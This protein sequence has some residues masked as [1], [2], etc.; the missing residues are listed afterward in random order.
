M[1]FHSFDELAQSRKEWYDVSA[2][3]GFL[4]GIEL[5]LTKLYPDKAHFI[6]ELLQ[7]AE[8]ALATRVEFVLQDDSLIFIHD[9][10]RLFDLRDV[11]SITSIADSTKRDDGTSIGKFGI[12]FK[13]VYAYTETPMIHSGDWHFKISHMV[14]PERCDNDVEFSCAP[15]GKTFFRFPFNNRQKGREKAYKEILDGLKTLEPESILFLRNISEVYVSYL[16]NEQIITRTITGNFVKLQKL[17]GRDEETS[18]RYLLFSKIIE[19]MALEDGSTVGPISVGIG[20]RL[21]K[22]EKVKKEQA[23]RLSDCYE[24]IPVER[25]NVYVFFPAE[26]EVSGLRFCLHAPFASTAARDSICDT[27]DNRRLMKVV[28]KLQVESLTYLRDEGFLTTEFLSVLPNS[29]DRIGDIYQCFHDNVVPVFQTQAF[30]PKKNGGHSPA[31]HL[32]QGSST[33]T[34][35]FND[36]D[37]RCMTGK[38]S[39]AWMK[40]A[41]MSNSPA[42]R[43]LDDLQVTR[44]DVNMLIAFLSRFRNGWHHEDYKKAVMEVFMKKDNQQLA[45]IYAFIEDGLP[46]HSDQLEEAVKSLRNAPIIRT[47]DGS[48]SAA[49]EGLVIGTL[50]K[51]Q[52]GGIRIKYVHPEITTNAHPSRQKEK[53][54]R[55][56]R[57]LGVEPFSEAAM[58]KML[59]DRYWKNNDC[60][61]T[62]KESADNL[63]LL[64]K[65]VLEGKIETDVASSFPVLNTDGRYVK[66]G[67]TFIDNPYEN[68]GLACYATPLSKSGITQLSERYF[69]LLEQANIRKLV[70]K[71]YSFGI[72]NKLWLNVSP[73]SK[74]PNYYSL[75]NTSNRVNQNRWSRDYDIPGLEY[76]TASPTEEQAKLIWE[77]LLPLAKCYFEACYG[78]NA[79]APVRRVSARYIQLL[80]KAKWI[81]IQ[82]QRGVFKKPSD[83]SLEDLPSDW[84]RPGCGCEQ[85]ALE[86]MNFGQETRCRLAEQKR[87]DQQYKELGFENAS[88][89]EACMEVKKACKERGM[90]LK[91]LIAQLSEER[92]Q[93]NRAQKE[94]PKRSVTDIKQRVSV[95]T[96]NFQQASEQRYVIVGR[97]VHVG[98]SRIRDDARTYLRAEYESDGEMFC[99]LCHHNM[100]FKAR[101]GHGY[102]EATQVFS[103]MKKDIAEQFI[104]LCP[105]CRAKYDEW[106]RRS[107]ERSRAFKESIIRHASQRGEES[108]EIQLPGESENRIKNP[109]SDKSVYFTGTHFVDLRQA[110]I[111]NEKLGGLD[112]FSE[113]EHESSNLSSI[114]SFFDWYSDNG[115]ECEETL[116]KIVNA[117]VKLDECQRQG[118]KNGALIWKKIC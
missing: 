81:P 87:R 34:D 95:A 86:A 101:D 115:S 17:T 40:K 12:G 2:K 61:M 75:I 58:M 14:V 62:E 48:L 83:V 23:L 27:E 92:K 77:F 109:L 110:V 44:L 9:G 46:N 51:S 80:A 18:S 36:D 7:N 91:E 106:V 107:P 10:K 102:F 103:R 59:V 90:T 112:D 84:K 29:R 76:F 68:T 64:I 113:L 6:F 41:S 24:V 38:V 94:F 74:N 93:R 69:N 30:T 54:V 79:S 15:K 19:K 11:E 97:S 55:F 71:C 31:Q 57:R 108:V 21:A 99:Q 20:Y 60:E 32:Y 35:I 105:T 73:I 50:I 111:E 42:D 16:D 104:S 53:A 98:N 117:V 5:L 96:K 85:P 1:S 88:E 82:G 26:K 56:L 8:D 22:R 100:P 66:L 37:L 45:A 72:K 3:N 13:A 39:A 65:L 114:P 49:S 52:V 47:A 28:S 89:F 116:N 70:E 67:Y 33:F 63:A 4:E 25:R 43:F 118:N 78:A